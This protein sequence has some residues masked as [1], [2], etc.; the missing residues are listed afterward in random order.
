VGTR[1]KC[2]QRNDFYWPTKRI[3]P[4]QVIADVEPDPKFDAFVLWHRGILLDHADPDLGCGV[5]RIDAG[6]LG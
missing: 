3:A 2:Q 5:Q 1:A 4:R 6:E